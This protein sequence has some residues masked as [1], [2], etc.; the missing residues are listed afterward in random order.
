MDKQTVHLLNG[1]LF[2]NTKEIL[3]E[4]N[5]RSRTIK[6]FAGNVYVCIVICLQG[7]DVTQLEL[8]KQS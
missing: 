7:F 3:S 5:Q 6:I 8:V 4:F 1:N 2:S